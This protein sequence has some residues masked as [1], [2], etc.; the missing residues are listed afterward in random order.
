M[1]YINIFA[2]L[3]QA[4]VYRHFR[5]WY[6][7]VHIH[8]Y[9]EQMKTWG[10]K[11]KAWLKK[12]C[13]TLTL[14]MTT[15]AENLRIRTGHANWYGLKLLESDGGV[16]LPEALPALIDHWPDAGVEDAGLAPPALDDENGEDP[17]QIVEVQAFIDEPDEEDLDPNLHEGWE[18]AESDASGNEEEVEPSDPAFAAGNTRTKQLILRDEY[19][20]LHNLGLTDRPAGCQIGVHPAAMKWR[21]FSFHA[22]SQHFARS[23]GPRSGRT[24]RKALLRVLE[25]MLEAHCNAVPKDSLAK[26]QLRKIKKT[27]VHLTLVWGRMGF[28]RPL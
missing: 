22:G 6:L 11:T 13:L 19:G 8:I 10:E 1:V 20:E 2:G 7:C 17:H 4:L 12:H 26:K 14:L 5:A 3:S 27:R 28:A 21:S 24:A 23:W 18:F 9:R 25:L 15:Q 16:Q